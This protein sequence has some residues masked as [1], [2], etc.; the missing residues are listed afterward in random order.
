M[1]FLVA[2]APGSKVSARLNKFLELISRSACFCTCRSFR[3]RETSAARMAAQIAA[4]R[5]GFSTSWRVSCP[6]H[7]R[8]V[9]FPPA[10]FILRGLVWR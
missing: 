8:S 3:G 2:T 1:I 5:A 4:R 9:A 7:H 6:A 10:H